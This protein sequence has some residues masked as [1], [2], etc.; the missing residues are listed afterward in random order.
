MLH[1]NV[2]TQR[3][4]RHTRLPASRSSRRHDKLSKYDLL[5]IDD[6]IYRLLSTE[7]ETARPRV[8]CRGSLAAC[9]DALNEAILDDVRTGNR[10]ALVITATYSGAVETVNGGRRD[11]TVEVLRVRTTGERP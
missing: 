6:P 8:L 5:M 10:A 11:L 7:S 2:A 3:C 9:L 1:A 4:Q